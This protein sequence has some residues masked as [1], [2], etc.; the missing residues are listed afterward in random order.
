MRYTIISLT[1]LAVASAATPAMAQDQTDPAPA[2]TVSGSVGVVSDYKFR[3]ISQTDG[4]FAVQGGITV[5]HE[6][7]FYIGTW[8]SSIDDY[9]TVH[10]TA[11]QELD[12]IAG[13]KKS[14]D[15]VTVD[16]G[17]VYYVYPGT[18][19]SGDTSA[20]DFIE[21]YLSVAY[22]VGPVTGKVTGNYAP[23]QKALAI[24]QGL[25]GAFKKEDNFYLAGD[26][27]VAIPNTPIGLTGHLGHT[28]GP[29]WLSGP[30]D[31]YTDWSIGATATWKSL[32]F[33]V[34]YVDTDTFFYTP[35]GKDVA[36]GGVIGSVSVA[37]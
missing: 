7:G 31:E 4:N 6:S 24:D 36:K 11:H 29:S 1:A 12:L 25:T 34:S 19:L 30:T 18:R 13:Y 8:G 15:G 2:I 35:S 27:S 21:P 20:S 37:F 28:W 10:G 9:V 32:T 5:S 14:F 16:V 23:K 26:L 22:S 17:A 3:G 33:G